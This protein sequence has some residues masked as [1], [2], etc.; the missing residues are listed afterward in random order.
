M[1]RS[2]FLDALEA[3]LR[4][5]KLKLPVAVEKAVCSALGERN[6]AAAICM[7]K[8]EPEPDP[9]LRDN[10]NVPLKEDVAEY[11]QR[12]VLPHIPD[13]WVDD[14][15]TVIGYEIPFTRHFYE[16]TPPRP[17]EVI[18]AEIRSLEDEVR[19]MLGEVLA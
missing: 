6:Q 12:E 10:E 11:M 18:E 14:K 16:Y 4:L 1:D 9:E 8:G 13:A 15:K 19:I 17:L 3:A 5:E 2:E 7:S